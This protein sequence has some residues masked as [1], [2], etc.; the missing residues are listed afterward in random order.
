MAINKGWKFKRLASAFNQEVKVLPKLI[1]NIAKNH[2]LVSFTKLD[3][4]NDRPAKNWKR[5][6]NN[7]GSGRKLLVKT[8]RLKK[9]VRFKP[10][11]NG[12]RIFN[13]VPYAAIHNFGLPGRLP[14]GEKF[15]M[16]E[17]KFIG[18]SSVLNKR[19]FK[20]ILGRSKKLVR[21]AR[22]L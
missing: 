6:S 22:K 18:E 13:S 21:K 9:G 16:P 3:R 8:S 4:F 19:I 11:G 20:F 12:V 17:R 5:R 2:Y 7:R 15:T 14:S 10:I 1:G